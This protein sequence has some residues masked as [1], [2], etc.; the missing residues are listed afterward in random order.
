M[1]NQPNVPHDRVD[2]YLAPVV[3]RL[4]VWLEGWSEMS[5]HD[6]ARRIAFTTNQEPRDAGGREQA[7]LQAAEHDVVL[8]GW[9]VDIVGRGL[10]LHHG[11]NQVVL[12]LPAGLQQ[13][14][15]T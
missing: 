13:F 2:L 4:D 6:I 10:R 9:A 1:A 5:A 12:G 7:L 11:E 8:H 14:L 3:L 15:A